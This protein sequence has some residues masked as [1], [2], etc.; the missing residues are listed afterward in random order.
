M[1]RRIVVTGLGVI[2]ALGDDVQTFWDACLK[3]HSVVSPIPDRWREFASF[4]SSIWSP[5]PKLDFESMGFSRMERQQL[6]PVAMLAGAASKQALASAGLSVALADRRANTFSIPQLD[7]KRCGVFMGTGVGGANTFMVNHAYHVLERSVLAL[8]ELKRDCDDSV[9]AA[10]EPIVDRL[11]HASRFSPF[12]VSMLMPNAVSAYV[13]IKFSLKGEN[14]TFAQACSSGTVA[15]GRAY[16]AIA[17]GRVDQA[18]AGGCEYLDDPHGS[19]FYGFDI[20]RTLVR[21]CDPPHSANRPFDEARSGFLFAQGG[22][23]VLMLEEAESAAR[24]GATPLA[25]IDGYAESFDAYSMMSPAPGGGEIQAMLKQLLDEAGVAPS[26]VDYVNAHG[27]GT[28]SNDECEAEVIERVFGR[29]VRV[30]STK[31]L[32]GHTIGASGAIEALVTTLSLR[33]QCLHPSINLTRPVAD[34]TF[35]T[36]TERASVRRAVS[37]SFAFGGHNAALLMSRS[38]SADG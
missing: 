2:S 29:D 35:V 4:R 38:P 16:R 14:V 24:R 8:S 32:L 20:A 5:L 12:A 11:Q 7:P 25:V 31:S 21:E 34:L 36:R 27:T 9:R 13:G 1:N 23:A 3:G 30:N 10:L 6:D 37:Q 18:L 17:A 19:I 15:I 28:K 33:D 22:S 26:D